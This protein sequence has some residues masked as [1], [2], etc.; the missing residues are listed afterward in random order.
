MID[1]DGIRVELIQSPRSFGQFTQEEAS[2]VSGGPP[3]AE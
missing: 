3:G 2:R 1:P